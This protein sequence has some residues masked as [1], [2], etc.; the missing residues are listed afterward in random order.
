[1]TIK[2]FSLFILIFVS[3]FFSSCR[4]EKKLLEKEDLFVISMGVMA[5]E[6]DYFYRDNS[7]LPG[8]SDL[9]V[10]NGRI[11]LTSSHAGKI[12]EMNSYGDLLSLVYNPQKNPEP[13]HFIKQDN[14]DES[15]IRIQ[16]WNFRNIEHIAISDE[17]MLVVDQV[18]ETLA[19]LSDQ[20]LYNRIILRFDEEGHY[21]DSLGQEGI[22]GTPF[23]YVKDLQ[24]T[25]QGDAVVVTQ[26]AA[27]NTVFWFSSEGQLLFQVNMDKE[28][29]PKVDEEGWSIGHAEKIAADQSEYK[30]YIKV[31]YFPIEDSPEQQALS[32]L[33]T[34]DLQDEEYTGFFDVS[35]FE[36]SLGEQLIEG[37]NEYLGPISGG[38]HFFMGSDYNG[39]YHLTIMD[40]EGAVKTSRIL[41]IQDQD[42]IFKKLY[43]SPNGLL[44]GIF[45]EDKGARVSWWRADHVAGKYA[46]N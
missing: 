9:F 25:A 42:I 14:Q 18:D 30:L 23:S 29:L 39:E 10:Q 34:L 20:V 4:A 15:L 22:N 28:H 2:H 7:L 40:N 37:V 38:L 19:I 13:S 3:L 12:M 1:L 21:I 36:I 27:D 35:R 33:Y 41:N 32:R 26:S 43:L 24:I 45:Y 16:K 31:D 17:A 11:F 44:T 46:Q 8:N 6:L 5:D